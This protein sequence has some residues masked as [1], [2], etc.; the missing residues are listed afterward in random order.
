MP[1]RWICNGSTGGDTTFPS[2]RALSR[3]PLAVRRTVQRK[4]EPV[5][6]VGAAA[7]SVVQPRRRTKQLQR[8]PQ[9]RM[10]RPSSKLQSK[11]L[12]QSHGR[13][14]R[15]LLRWP[16][17]PPLPCSRFVAAAEDSQERRATFL[18]SCR[19]R[20]FRLL[21]LVRLVSR[22]LRRSPPTRLR[23]PR[24]PG[25][26]R[27]KRPRLQRRRLPP[28]NL[29]VAHVVAAVVEPRSKPLRR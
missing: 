22:P 21:R 13:P 17:R 12:R 24:P 23:L 29:A 3:H 20:R 14:T 11:P 2:G 26:L 7:R 28:R 9:Y 16:L 5:Q 1:T 8:R 4:A 15:P 27:R 10:H 25:N 6:G 18:Q 19:D